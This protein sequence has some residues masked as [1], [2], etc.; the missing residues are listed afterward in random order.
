MKLTALFGKISSKTCPCCNGV[1]EHDSGFECYTCDSGGDVPRGTPDDERCDGRYQDGGPSHAFGPLGPEGIMCVYPHLSGR[2]TAG[3]YHEPPT[4][5]EDLKDQVTWT[6]ARQYGAEERMVSDLPDHPLSSVQHAQQVADKVTKK[7]GVR[8]VTV[9]HA[10]QRNYSFAQAHPDRGTPRIVLGQGGMDHGTLLHELAHHIDREKGTQDPEEVHGDSFRDHFEHALVDHHPNSYV[11]REAFRDKFH[12]TD[13][14][15]RRGGRALT[16]GVNPEMTEREKAAPPVEKPSPMWQHDPETLRNALNAVR[17]RTEPHTYLK[18][19]DSHPELDYEHDDDYER[20]D[21]HMADE[22]LEKGMHPRLVPPHMLDAWVKHHPNPKAL[23]PPEWD[24]EKD[25]EVPVRHTAARELGV[26][27]PPDRWYHASPHWLEEDGFEEGHVKRGADEDAGKHWNSHLGIH[28]TSDHLTARELAEE[29]HGSVHHVSLSM[30]NP[31]HYPSEHDLTDEAHGWTAAHPDFGKDLPRNEDRDYQ[32]FARREDDLRHHPRIA[33]VGRAF[34]DHLRSQG[35]DGITYGNEYE[36]PSGHLSAIAFSPHEAE[37]DGAHSWGD[38][39]DEHLDDRPTQYAAGRSDHR[40]AARP[41]YREDLSDDRPVS[42]QYHRNTTPAPTQVNHYHGQDI[43]PHGQYFSPG[44]VPVERH[45]EGM[46]YGSKTFQRPLRLHSPTDDPADPEHWKQQLSRRYDGK[47][48]RD[49]SQAVRDDGYDAIL[50]HDTYGPSESVDLTSITPRRTAAA[51]PDAGLIHRGVSVVL[52]EHIHR[53]VHDESQPAPARAHMLL[54]E[55]RKQHPE[56]TSEEAHGTTGGLGNFWSPHKDKAAEYGDQGGWKAYHDHEREH[57]CGGYSSSYGGCPTTKVVLHAG[58]PPEK[59]HWHEVFRGQEKYDPE[60]SWRL[61]VRPGAP[62]MVHGISWKQGEDN[63]PHEDRAEEKAPFE[64]YD[65]LRPVKKRATVTMGPGAEDG[66]YS[67]DM[68]DQWHPRLQPTIHRHMGLSLPSGHPAHDASLPMEDRAR[69]LVEHASKGL[70][71]GRGIGTHWTDDPAYNHMD[72]RLQNGETHVVLH[73]QTP[74]RHHIED[75]DETLEDRAV[76]DWDSD[77]ERE[78]PLRHKAP[79]KI[80]GVSWQSA[81]GQQHH[82]FEQ[83]ITKRA[84]TTDG[85]PVPD[86]TRGTDNEGHDVEMTPQ[87]GWA[88]PDGSHGHEDGSN[89]GD[90]PVYTQDHTWLPQGRYWGPNSAQNDQRLFDGDH[91]RPEVRRDILDRVGGVLGKYGE[92]WEKWTRVY[93][94]GSQ[95]AQWLDQN[96]Q[97]NGD[98]DILIGVDFDEF[99]DRNP[100][101]EEAEDAEIATTLTDELWSRANVK[102]YYFTLADGKTVGP[103]DRTFF[104]NP[105]AWDIKKIHPY[106]AYNVT[107]DDWVV[108]PLQVPKDWNAT[109][110]PESY[111]A[112]AES[113]LNEVKAIGT[114]PAE[115]RQRMAA[116]LWEELH[117]HR[118]DAFGDKGHGLFDLSNVVEKFLAQFPEDPSPWDKLTQWKNESPSG[119]SSWVPTTARRTTLTEIFGSK[120]A[121]AG[122]DYGGMMIA[123]VPPKKICRDLAIEDGEPVEAMHV[124]LAY[125][126]G[127]DEYTKEQRTGL[128]DLVEGWARTQK[129]LEAHVGGVGTFVNPGQHVLWAAV[130]IPGGGPLR[131]SLVE[132]LERHGYSVRNDHGWTPHLTL[133]YD[134]NHFRFM[135]KV[136]PASWD[137]TEVTVCVGGTWEAVSLG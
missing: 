135:P 128:R 35:H 52:P 133:S 102:D 112:Y 110:L 120:T 23:E 62:L 53:F 109:H 3:E 12:R 91:L 136:K 43:E 20:G 38:D 93:F 134:K 44:E 96:G 58:T 92:D 18:Y 50:T 107:S 123:L 39:D 63:Q 90:H 9:Q 67:R 16:F 36:G 85:G 77:K 114:L 61:P 115:E 104:V 19:M 117:T 30:K 26:Y 21:A 72:G 121:A 88:H 37:I 17:H 31:R 1:G 10:P 99:R 78:V 83:P 56:I 34:R 94:A 28:V 111:W 70:Y 87:D 137:V 103:F 2:R 8:P 79:V 42:L 131:E 55:T 82:T 47:T 86:G 51:D 40:T 27:G 57:H 46:E 98:F 125:L 4:R 84:T 41:P 13:Q 105:R 32:P 33:E 14:L 71:G 130:D 15:M 65:F 118:S 126:G 60:I 24:Y 129:P 101:F 25:E 97:G 73:A 113:L 48:G 116:N 108:H 80:I 75:D 45:R 66:G 64:R 6:Q 127:S 59:H 11:A 89:V 54:S 5:F 95:A 49:L 7:A 119:A 100:Q 76:R 22:D 69:S 122:A 124:T 106:A 29:M 132:T 74:Q 68:W 81:D